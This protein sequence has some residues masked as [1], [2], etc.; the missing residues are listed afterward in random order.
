MCLVIC[1]VPEICNVPVI[2]SVLV[3]SN[4]HVIGTVPVIGI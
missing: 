2:G 3:T 4:R 1:L